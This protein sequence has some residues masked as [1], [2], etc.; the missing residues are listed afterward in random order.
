MSAYTYIVMDAK[1]TEM[2]VP[3]LLIEKHVPLKGDDDVK[4]N[5]CLETLIKFYD[6]EREE[7]MLKN[8]IEEGGLVSL[9]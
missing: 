5:I 3:E 2:Q 7:W 8:A 6:E 9:S 4:C 1:E